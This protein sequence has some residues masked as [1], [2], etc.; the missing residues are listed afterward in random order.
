MDRIS[1]IDFEASGLQGYPIEVGV[2]IYNPDRELISVWS[3][4]IKPTRRWLQAMNWDP[5]AEE[6]HGISPVDLHEAPSPFDVGQQLNRLLGPL[7]VTYCDGGAFDE[8]WLR[9]LMA[10]CPG[11]PLF[12]LLGLAA[13]ASLLAV[14][15]SHLIDDDSVL[16]QHRAAADAEQLLRRGLALASG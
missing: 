5:D 2:A 3:S 8:R 9:L 4:L 7:G 1:I 12:R 14:P 16:I 13:F 11:A 6:L 15:V 10:E